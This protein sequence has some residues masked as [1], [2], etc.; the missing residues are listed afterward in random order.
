ME[1]GLTIK[2]IQKEQKFIVYR[3]EN[4]LGIFTIMGI[5]KYIT[6]GISK[7][8][9]EMVEYEQ[10][11][12]F[13][14]K[15]FCKV[16]ENGEVLLSGYL[17]SPIMGNIEVVMKIYTEL[18]KIENNLIQYEIN[19]L[20]DINERKNITNKIK[21]L[22]YLILNHS[23]KLIINISDV[24]K[25]DKER[26]LLKY[27][28]VK[29]SIF[30]TNKINDLMCE[31]INDCKNEYNLLELEFEQMKKIKNY[32]EKKL[33]LFEKKISLQE[34]KIDKIID[35]IDID[36]MDDIINIEENE[37]EKSSDREEY[38]FNDSDND[39]SENNGKNIN[40]DYLTPRENM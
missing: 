37:E 21:D 39:Y 1:K 34:S 4:L 17:D 19:K 35:Y 36:D 30:I 29:Y 6:N 14:E 11:I 18:I 27:S 7:K 2:F 22:F 12:E 40:I 31:K 13:I 25:N 9:L 5:I 16:N 23:L 26:E 32:S 10:N 8:F 3:E 28:L 20:E 33:S 15:F 24:I 38:V